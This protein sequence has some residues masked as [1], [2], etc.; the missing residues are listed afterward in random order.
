MHYAYHSKIV[1]FS[2]VA[3]SFGLRNTVDYE[4][5]LSEMIRVVKKMALY[6]A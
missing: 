4:K 5:V 2:A 3:I 6:I 1:V